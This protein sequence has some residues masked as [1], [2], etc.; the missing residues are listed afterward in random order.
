MSG[1]VEGALQHLDAALPDDE[2]VTAHALVAFAAERRATELASR[3][4]FG[5]RATRCRTQLG[6]A[7]PDSDLAFAVGLSAGR[8]HNLVR[9]S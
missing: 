8:K 4:L 9:K 2:S 5:W 3:R 1:F 6:A 7:A